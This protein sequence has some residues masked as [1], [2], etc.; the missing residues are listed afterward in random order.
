M[1]RKNFSKYNIYETPVFNH[2]I[3]IWRDMSY[4]LVQG[5]SDNYYLFNIGRLP[6][7]AGTKYVYDLLTLN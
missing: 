1:G 4:L 2:S 5:F 3:V 7:F 6:F